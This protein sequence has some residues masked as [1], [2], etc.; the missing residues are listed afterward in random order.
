MDG[1]DGRMTRTLKPMRSDPDSHLHWDSLFAH[2][3]KYLELSAEEKGALQELDVFR[4]YRKGEVLRLEG[5]SAPESFFVVRGCIR[6]F[7]I[8]DDVEH[9]LDFI[10]EMEGYAPS[11]SME[12][13]PSHLRAACLEPCTLIVSTPEMEQRMFERFPRFETLCRIVAEKQL[14]RK[15]LEHENFRILDAEERYLKLIEARPDLTQRVPQRY[16]A[17]FLGI[18][19]E[20]LSRIRRRLARGRK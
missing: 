11:N 9:T 5:D 3:G 14:A 2:L 6:I 4:S 13:A 15:Q 20:T 1:V 12:A 8:K 17:G 18:R 16:L 7:R 19:P 10:T